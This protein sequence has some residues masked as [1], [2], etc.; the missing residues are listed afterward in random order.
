MTSPASFLL[1]T[2][3]AIWSSGWGRTKTGCCPSWSEPENSF[4][5]D[6]KWFSTYRR[7]AKTRQSSIVII[8]YIKLVL[9]WRWLV[10]IVCSPWIELCCNEWQH[11]HGQDDKTPDHHRPWHYYQDAWWFVLIMYIIYIYFTHCCHFWTKCWKWEPW[12][13]PSLLGSGLNASVSKGWLL[14]ISHCRSL[15]RVFLNDLWWRRHLMPPGK[16]AFGP[17]ATISILYRFYITGSD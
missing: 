15:H 13:C 4:C 5:F 17:W 6:P 1:I 9:I 3:V 12:L 11:N 16:A 2:V 7:T 14:V 10:A 8:Y